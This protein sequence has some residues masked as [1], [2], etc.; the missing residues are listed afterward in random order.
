M[1]FRI[2]FGS[3]LVLLGVGA[4]VDQ[5][6]PFEFWH[7]VSLIWPLA[8]VL[9]GLMFLFTRSTTFL[10]SA[11]LLVF[12]LLM[13]VSTLGLAG[14]NF[15]DLFWPSLIILAGVYMLFW[16]GRRPGPSATT[17]DLIQHFVIFSGLE[18]RHT[19]TNFRGGTVFTAFG[20]SNIDLRD[21]TL[22]PEGALL[23]ITAAFGGI[24]VVVP[25][26]W[27]LHLSGL[28]L[29]SGWSDK[30]RNHAASTGPLVTVRCLAMFG[31]I[32]FKN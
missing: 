3:L 31:G 25:D 2:W 14:N 9:L 19:N 5:V 30:T 6:Y 8:I 15:W 18:T 22:A 21:V 32:D 11:I 13:E 7:W 17:G 28:P 10:G 4:M 26:G 23:E 24:T 1:V 12:G 29:F 20:G 16:M 27:R